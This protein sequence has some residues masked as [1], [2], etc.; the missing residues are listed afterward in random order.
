MKEKIGEVA[1]KIWKTL[2]EKGEVNLALL[3]KFLKEKSEVAY[4]SLGW[5]AHEGKIIYFKKGERNFI[6]LNDS[7]RQVFKTIH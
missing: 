2:G 4:Q 6:A 5:L 3:P 1:G 7:E